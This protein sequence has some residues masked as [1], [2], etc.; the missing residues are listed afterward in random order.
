MYEIAIR[1]EPWEW[2]IPKFQKVKEYTISDI[3]EIIKNRYRYGSEYGITSET[4]LVG[5][6]YGNINFPPMCLPLWVYTTKV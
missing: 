6:F 5:E 4:Y 1:K 2:Y 3:D